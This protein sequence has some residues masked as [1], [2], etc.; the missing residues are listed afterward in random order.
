MSKYVI[1]SLLIAIELQA[2]AR[3]FE[4]YTE[5]EEC[6]GTSPSTQHQ[7]S[8]VKAV[9]RGRDNSEYDPDYVRVSGFQYAN[10]HF[11]PLGG[12]PPARR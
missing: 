12:A 2:R 3:I 11:P 1:H 9:Y 6:S 5:S 4:G 10:T 7:S 8:S